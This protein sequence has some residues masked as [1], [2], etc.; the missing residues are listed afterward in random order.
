MSAEKPC[1]RKRALQFLKKSPTY[2]QKSPL[3]GVYIIKKAHVEKEREAAVSKEPYKSEKEPYISAKDP[4]K[5]AKETY[6]YSKRQMWK[7]GKRNLREN[8]F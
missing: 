6:T 5:S 1:I 3:N 8:S 7:N 4:Y 2:T